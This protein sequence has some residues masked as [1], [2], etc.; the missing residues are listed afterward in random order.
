[1]AKSADGDADKTG[2][3]IGLPK[4]RRTASRTEMVSDL[5]FFWSITLIGV[6][7]AFGAKVLLLEIGTDTEHRAGPPLTLATMTGDNSIWFA[8][9]LD[10]QGAASAMP[11]SRHSL[12]HDSLAQRWP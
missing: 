4:H 2:S 10:A 11:G 8:G 3:Q 1:L 12:L 6:V 7:G 5:S 9:R